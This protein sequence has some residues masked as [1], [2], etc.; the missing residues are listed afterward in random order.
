MEIRVKKNELL[1]GTQRVQ[2]AITDKTQAVMSLKASSDNTLLLNAS[3]R[4]LATYCQV[5]C[6]VVEKGVC[7]VKNLFF[8]SFGNQN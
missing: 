2:G 5:T 6:T 3:D 4:V 7:F 1:I 8:P